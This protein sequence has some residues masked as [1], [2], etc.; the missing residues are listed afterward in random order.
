M[1]YLFLNL[2][3]ASILVCAACCAFAAPS[4]RAVMVVGHRGASAYAPENTMTSFRLAYE[5]GADMIELDVHR[6]TDGALVVMHDDDVKRVTGATGKISEMTLEQVRALDAGER[7]NKKFKGEKVPTL[8]EVLAWAADK[9]MVNIEI[10][11]PGCEEKVVELVKKYKMVDKVIVSSF[12]HSIVAKIK[13][14]EPAVKTGALVD[15][16]KDIGAVIKECHPDAIN[17]RYTALTKKQI[18]DAHALGLQ[19]NTYTPNDGVSM[20][21]LISYGVDGIITNYPDMLIKLLKGRKKPP[22]PVQ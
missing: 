4:G 16:I 7:F 18:A 6:T 17:P 5:M 14:L 20:R 12:D 8:D 2:L 10:K 22:A 1:R 19:V 9:I 13:E 3:A 15:D 11:A 21:Q